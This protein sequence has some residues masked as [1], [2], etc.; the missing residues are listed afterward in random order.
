M[1]TAQ[2]PANF[3][4]EAKGCTE[5]ST[6]AELIRVLLV[7]DHPMVREG[8]RLF[9]NTS[10]EMQVVGEAA[11][12]P[13]AIAAAAQTQPTVILLD[14]VLQEEDGIQAITPLR[15]M[16]PQAKILALS[17]FTEPARMLRLLQAGAQGFLQKTIKP[18]D[19]LRAIRQV[20]TGM[21]VLDP[22]ALQVLQGGV[23]HALSALGQANGS[24]HEAFATLPVP[25]ADHRTL[26]TALTPREDQVL[27]LLCRALANKEI[28]SVLGISE[29]TVKVHVSHILAKLDVYDRSGAII[30][31][32]RLGLVTL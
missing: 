6:G 15:E 25:S 12:V 17:S 11:T 29:K 27:S 24:A 16:V 9:L 13:D 30:A 22:I 26:P 8:L 4:E 18:P 21:T 28:A 14:L 5:G 20:A 1:A 19:L 23:D 2:R 32:V 3:E 31:A 7:D 10:S